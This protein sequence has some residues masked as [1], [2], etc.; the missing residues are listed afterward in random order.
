[1]ASTASLASQ[2]F[3]WLTRLLETRLVKTLLTTKFNGPCLYLPL[4]RVKAYIANGVDKNIV[5]PDPQKKYTLRKELSGSLPKQN[6][7]D[8]KSGASTNDLDS[9]GWPKGPYTQQIEG[10]LP[11]LLTEDIVTVHLKLSGKLVHANKRRKVSHDGSSS[12]YNIDYSTLQREHQYFMESYI[13]GRFIHFCCKHGQVWIQA[14]CYR[15]QKKNDPMHQLKI[16]LAKD[17]PHYVTKAYC[18]CIA[19][20]SGMCSH[21]VGLLKQLIHYVMMKVK[22]VPV[23]LTCTQMQQTWHKPRP[24]QIEAELVMNV[25]FCK[26][27]Q[28]QTT[29]KREPIV[30]MLYEARAQAVQEYSFKQQH[31]LKKGLSVCHPGCA[32]AQI[33]L[34]VPPKQHIATH[35]GHAPKVSSLSYQLTDYEKPS[36]VKPDMSVC[37]LPPLPITAINTMPSIPTD[38]STE[39]QASLGKLKV[40]LEEAHQL[41]Q[42]TQQQ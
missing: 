37:N 38:I 9:D 20:K 21:V 19:G 35:F 1:M 26:A 5:D 15:S 33:L 42:S 8:C 25:A 16:A 3:Q 36:V 39:Q 10:V 31:D 22:A 32:F 18:S 34:N 27:S 28:T 30:C 7:D 12:Y 6:V 24:S 14:R 13:P 29:P 4:H 23:D 17:S 41:E 40:T 2:P 11:S